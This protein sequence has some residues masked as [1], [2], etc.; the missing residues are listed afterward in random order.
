VT[1]PLIGSGVS[2]QLVGG[3]T[4]NRLLSQQAAEIVG[5][6]LRQEAEGSGIN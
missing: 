6:A 4:D 2:P 1:N 5:V 3:S